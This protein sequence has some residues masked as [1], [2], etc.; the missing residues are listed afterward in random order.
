MFVDIDVEGEDNKAVVTLVKEV[1]ITCTKPAYGTCTLHQPPF[2]MNAWYQ[3]VHKDM[4]IECV[5]TYEPTVHKPHF[6]RF[7]YDMDTE[8]SSSVQKSV[9]LTLNRLLPDT[10][11]QPDDSVLTPSSMPASPEHNLASLLPHNVSMPPLQGAWSNMFKGV[12]LPPPARSNSQS[13]IWAS[14]VAGK[15]SV[16]KPIPGTANVLVT[17]PAP[18]GGVSRSTSLVSRTSSSLTGHTESSSS[19]TGLISGSTKPCVPGDQ[20]GV[21]EV[22]GGRGMKVTF[23]L[24][25]TEIEAGSHSG[26]NNS[27]ESGFS[28][29]EIHQTGQKFDKPGHMTKSV[30][31]IKQQQPPPPPQRHR[32]QNHLANNYGRG[33]GGRNAYRKQDDYRYN[34]NHRGRPSSRHYGQNRHG[35]N[36]RYF[37]QLEVT[38]KPWGDRRSRTGSEP[39]NSNEVRLGYQ[40]RRAFSGGHTSPF[41]SESRDEAPHQEGT[42]VEDST[43]AKAES[44]S[45]EAD[46][47][48]QH[49]SYKKHRGSKLK[50][51]YW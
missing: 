3:G 37:D 20:K 19:L 28:E 29:K 35:Q 50:R 21:T 18:S 42:G 12:N 49:V 14:I 44:N 24:D 43:H 47:G 4:V 17:D 13:N 41:G 25:G 1:A 36:Q 31:P 7:K 45:K 30:L 33:R 11:V 40:F 15:K 2:I 26:T 27:S 10:P 46:N 39:H 51:G 8:N 23:S 5:V 6:T 9:T 38:E 48:F 32:G 22:G 16:T 34:N